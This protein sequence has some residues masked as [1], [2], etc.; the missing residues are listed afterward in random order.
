MNA[1]AILTSPLPSISARLVD[2]GDARIAP[3]A[4]GQASILIFVLIGSL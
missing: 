1:F 4:A 3:E 2:F